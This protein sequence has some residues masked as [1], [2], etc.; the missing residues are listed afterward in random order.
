MSLLTENEKTIIK[1][2]RNSPYGRDFIAN[3]IDNELKQARIQVDKKANK[4]YILVEKDYYTNLL[5]SEKTRIVQIINWV[6]YLISIS[7][8]LINF[9]DLSGYVTLHKPDITDN[10]TTIGPGITDSNA[11]EYEIKDPTIVEYLIKYID[12]IVE[13]KEEIENL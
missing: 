6:M 2:L 1:R 3:V 10:I 4:A 7:F 13:L 12:S 8:G 5:D 9:L 11:H